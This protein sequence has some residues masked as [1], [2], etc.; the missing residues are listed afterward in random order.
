[1]RNVQAKGLYEPARER[2]EKMLDL[3]LCKWI[4]YFLRL[5]I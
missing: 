1:M 2:L 4:N 3:L 5:N